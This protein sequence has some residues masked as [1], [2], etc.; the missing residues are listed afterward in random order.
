VFDGLVGGPDDAVLLCGALALVLAGGLVPLAGR[1]LQLAFAYLVLERDRTTGRQ[2]LIAA[3]WPDA[4]PENPTAALRT[5][6]SRLRCAL[7]PEAITGRDRIRL[8]LPPGIRVDIEEARADAEAAEGALRDERWD[9]AAAAGRRAVR[10]LRA[11]FLEGMD[12]PWVDQRRREVQQQCLRMLEVVATA[13]LQQPVPDLIDAE[14]AARTLIELAPLREGGHRLLMEALAAR[15][16]TAEAL[17]AYE[18]ARRLL[19]EELGIVP[20]PELVR[21]H[22]EL[23]RAADGERRDV[24]LSV[25]EQRRLA[26]ALDLFDGDVDAMLDAVSSYLSRPAGP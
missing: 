1:R 9:D 23:L 8:E 13:G 19:R 17:Q 24:P 11:G 22:G 4:P 7:G 18:R 14:R 6:L 5:V 21:R 16:E 12:A 15:G 26:A 2:E 20:G 25:T 3:V 10:V